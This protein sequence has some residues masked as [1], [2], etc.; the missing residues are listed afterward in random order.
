MNPVLARSLAAISATCITVTVV[1]IALGHY[2]LAPAATA[3]LG[4]S[5][6]CL[7]G[8]RRY[9]RRHRELERGRWS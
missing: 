6:G 2:A 8:S 1:I 3:V 5:I 9:L 7:A 4:C